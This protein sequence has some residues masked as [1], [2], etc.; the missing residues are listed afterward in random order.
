MRRLWVTPL[1]SMLLLSAC[2]G[3][4]LTRDVHDTEDA[5]AC[6]SATPECLLGEVVASCEG[7][8]AELLASAS[9]GG[10]LRQRCFE[11]C[12]SRSGGSLDGQAILRDRTSCVIH[13]KISGFP[14][15]ACCTL[16]DKPFEDIYCDGD[17]CKDFVCNDPPGEDAIVATCDVPPS[18]GSCTRSLSETDCAAANGTWSCDPCP[19]L[20]E[21]YRQCACSCPTTDAGCPCLLG[22]D[23]CQGYCIFPGETKLDDNACTQPGYC[24]E[25]T[26]RWRSGCYCTIGPG[27]PYILCGC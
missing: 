27:G 10:S 2:P 4:E 5:A 22:E 24:S 19:G 16:S 15:E 17:P 13:I 25:T 18:L 26:I 6:S 20:P 8:V 14:C 1:A 21:G 9:G 3:E 12:S 23:N 11:E 7:V